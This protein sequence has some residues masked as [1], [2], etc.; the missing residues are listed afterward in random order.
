MSEGS[1]LSS[2]ELAMTG[3]S[4]TSI[5]PSQFV[6]DVYQVCRVTQCIRGTGTSYF[7]LILANDIGTCE[8]LT[9]WS[10]TGVA[11]GDA[12]HVRG[13]ILRR[14]NKLVLVACLLRRV[15]HR[16]IASTRPHCNE[17]IGV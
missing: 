2:R 11:P 9:G 10:A 6:D 13:C 16:L 12:V 4:T 7:A 1:H 5:R 14:G 15:S 8:A 3:K 17:E